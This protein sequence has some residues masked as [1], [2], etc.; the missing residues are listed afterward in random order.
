MSYLHVPGRR[1]TWSWCWLSLSS[2]L[3]STSLLFGF[4]VPVVKRILDEN[5][6]R[7]IQNSQSIQL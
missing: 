4:F 2:S 7:P 3:S 1:L 5:F 6:D